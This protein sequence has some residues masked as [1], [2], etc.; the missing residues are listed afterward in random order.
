[1]TFEE[2]MADGRKRRA[3]L[4]A[5][6]AAAAVGAV[7]VPAALWLRDRHQGPPPLRPNMPTPSPEPTGSGNVRIAMRLRPTWLPEEMVELHRGAQRGGV[8]QTRVWATP[9]AIAAMRSPDPGHTSLE[10]S[11]TLSILPDMAA[12]PQRRSPANATVGG[13]PA[14][15]EA[16]AGGPAHLKWYLERDVLV[17]L[18]V[19]A[20]S[21]SGSVAQRIAHALVRDVVAGCE[22]S[23]R[24]GWLP[25]HASQV[26]DIDISGWNGE[27]FQTLGARPTK[28]IGYEPVWAYLV[29]D[30]SQLFDFV[31]GDPAT[32][33][34]RPGFAGIG[35]GYGEA[36]VELDG[37]RWLRVLCQSEDDGAHERDCAVR[38]AN[39]LVIG[40]DPYLGWVGRR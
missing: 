9:G 14:W 40:P 4:L 25:P 3:L 17:T 39:D 5:G 35:G 7:G 21:D 37:G 13:Q 27:W 12:A 32:I 6:A 20:I 38:V 30:R 29:S 1:M 18:D 36:A 2:Y 22:T 16:S 10:G 24:F 8:A 28:N 31:E 34:G 23:M 33:R 26:W 19:S 11:V 15:L